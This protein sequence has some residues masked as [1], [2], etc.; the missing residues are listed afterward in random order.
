MFHTLTRRCLDA[1]HSCMYQRNK[2]QSLM[3]KQPHASSS[4]MEMRSSAIGYGFREAKDS[5]KPRRCVS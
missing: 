5:Q 4:D 1:K 2:D 3:I